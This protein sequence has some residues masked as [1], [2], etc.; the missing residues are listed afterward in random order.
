VLSQ[1]SLCFLKDSLAGGSELYG[2]Y[3]SITAI[4]I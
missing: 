2:I 4:S 3:L 1:L